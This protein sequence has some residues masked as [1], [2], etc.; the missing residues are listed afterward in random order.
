M[1]KKGI[2]KTVHYRDAGTGQY[3]TPKY[4]EKHPK[5]TVKETDKKLLNVSRNCGCPFWAGGEV[6]EVLHFY[7]MD[8]SWLSMNGLCMKPL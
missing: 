4:A 3:V 8:W 5:T 6:G 1:S 2:T 7:I